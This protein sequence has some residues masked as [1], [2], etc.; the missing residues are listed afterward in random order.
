MRLINRKASRAQT[1]FRGYYLIRAWQ[2]AF[3][4]AEQ[5]ILSR[6]YLGRTGCVRRA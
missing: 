3:R 2:I 1:Q 4:N 6:L 5:P